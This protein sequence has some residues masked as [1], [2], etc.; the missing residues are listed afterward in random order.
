ML[1]EHSAMTTLRAI[2]GQEVL[3]LRNARP[4]GGG[5]ATQDAV[6]EEAKAEGCVRAVT[7]K[8]YIINYQKL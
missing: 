8:K 5:R 1:N 3:V 7:M 6:A 2:L 4:Q